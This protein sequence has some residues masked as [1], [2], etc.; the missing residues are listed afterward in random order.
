MVPA[1]VVIIGSSFPRA[2]APTR[3]DLYPARD[4]IHLE[5]MKK[6]ESLWQG[7]CFVFDGR[8]TVDHDLAPGKAVLCKHCHE[9][10]VNAESICTYCG[11][12][13]SE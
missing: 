1:A 13:D 9:V 12:Y 6:D 11:K 8:V 4:F 10:K 3:T 5:Q 7:E 2:D